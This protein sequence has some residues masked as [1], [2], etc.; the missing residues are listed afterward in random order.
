MTEVYGMESR[1]L[2]GT[3]TY[4]NVRRFEPEVKLL[5]IKQE[6]PCADSHGR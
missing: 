5:G 4:T 3:A 1:T 2:T 6:E